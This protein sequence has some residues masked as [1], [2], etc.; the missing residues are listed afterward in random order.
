MKPKP[1]IVIVP[2]LVLALMLVLVLSACGQS[3]G[4][5]Y[6]AHYREALQTQHSDAAIK[7]AMTTN[8]N[9]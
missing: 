2:F 9:Q 8:T 6:P 7:I 3:S 1:S 5:G 4:P